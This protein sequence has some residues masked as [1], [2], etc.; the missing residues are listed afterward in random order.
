MKNFYC[1]NTFN[2]NIKKVF[3]QSIL[4]DKRLDIQI[5]Y[6]NMSFNDYKAMRNV[7]VLI[8]EKKWL[9]KKEDIVNLL[10]YPHIKAKDIS[11]E[12]LFTFIYS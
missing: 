1:K 5:D 10:L 6:L 7:S 2:N 8:P 11:I 4:I 12:D 9:H 3:K